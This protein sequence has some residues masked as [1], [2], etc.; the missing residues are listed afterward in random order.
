MGRADLNH[1][2]QIVK[3]MAKHYAE[4]VGPWSAFLPIVDAP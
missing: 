4:V 3:A 2:G 1:L